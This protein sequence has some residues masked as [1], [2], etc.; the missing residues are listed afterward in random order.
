MMKFPPLLWA[1]PLLVLSS[2]GLTGCE[3]GG[4][5]S[6]PPPTDAASGVGATTTPADSGASA[7]HTEPTYMEEFN[8]TVRSM[9]GERNDGHI[10]H[11]WGVFNT[12]K[13]PPPARAAVSVAFDTR[14][15]DR[16]NPSPRQAS[17]ARFQVS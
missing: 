4:D 9:S 7:V 16:A 3:P 12:I 8:D 10:K 15:A 13:A 2:A 17:D 5:N 14:R 11:G 1:I 6:R